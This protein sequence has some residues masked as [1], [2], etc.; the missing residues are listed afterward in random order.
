MPDD[1]LQLF[2]T[3]LLRKAYRP[4]VR[5]AQPN[6]VLQC[7]A[8]FI[9]IIDWAIETESVDRQLWSD[10]CETFSNNWPHVCHWIHPGRLSDYLLG[11]E[12]VNI[13]FVGESRPAPRVERRKPTVRARKYLC[14]EC[15]VVCNS[16]C[17]FDVH[18]KGKKHS[19]LLAIVEMRY[20]GN[21]ESRSP[22]PYEGNADSFY[23]VETSEQQQ[24]R[25]AA[26]LPPP[27]FSASASASTSQ[28]YS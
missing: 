22:L 12:K 6:E 21:Y 18:K 5:E 20:D 3:R 1:I 7:E 9:N 2:K 24:N 8:D 16:L 23:F 13:K 19:E 26:P 25:P 17:Q 27:P 4:G 11:C 15:G 28:P 14:Q 10:R